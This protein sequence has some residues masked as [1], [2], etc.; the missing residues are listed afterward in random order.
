MMTA[1][2]VGTAAM[3]MAAIGNRGVSG[4]SIPPV[5]SLQAHA[6]RAQAAIKRIAGFIV[7]GS[8]SAQGSS[9]HGLLPPRLGAARQPHRFCPAAITSMLAHGAVSS[10]DV[11]VRRQ[12][13]GHGLA[14]VAGVF[15]GHALTVIFFGRSGYSTA[16]NKVVTL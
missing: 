8:P 1:L 15:I 5:K 3:V 16:L 2:I 13:N 9:F 10:L 14:G 6:V 11:P 12:A 7:M 4:I